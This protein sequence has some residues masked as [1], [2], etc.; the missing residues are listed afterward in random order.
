MK[1]KVISALA[2]LAVVT[3]F[4][5]SAAQSSSSS[6]ETEIKEEVINEIEKALPGVTPAQAEEIFKAIPAFADE[7]KGAPVLISALEKPAIED[8]LAA[9]IDPSKPTVWRFGINIFG[10]IVD[11]VRANTLGYAVPVEEAEGE[12]EGD[13]ATDVVGYIFVDIA[14]TD[15]EIAADGHPAIYNLGDVNADRAVNALDAVAVLESYAKVGPN[16][17][18]NK[19]ADVDGDK[20]VNALDAAS[21]L[22]YY[23]KLGY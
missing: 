9:G 18:A 7:F 4:G 16:L 6:T 15:V 8:L 5:A 12:E 10:T 11:S 17:D 14:G 20:T 23:A 2:A 21:V 19:Y 22:S 3:A 13:A 1:T